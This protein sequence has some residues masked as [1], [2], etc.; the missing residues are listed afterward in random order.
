MILMSVWSV[1]T[2]ATDH[3]A[4]TWAKWMKRG[5]FY[6]YLWLAPVIVPLLVYVFYPV[7]SMIYMSGY[8]Y[9]IVRPAETHFVGLDNYIQLLSDTDLWRSLKVSAIWVLGSVAPQ[10]LLGLGMALLLHQRFGGRGAARTM[11][12]MPWVL[13]GVVTGII[14]LWL[15]DGTIGVINDLLLRA[16]LVER[17][18]AWSIRPG[19]AFFMLF[20]ANAWRGAPFFAIT[21]LAALQGIS[22]EIYEAAE[23]D[24]AGSWQRFR[25]VTIPLIMNVVI[26]TTLL[27]A[28]WTFNWVDLIWTMTKGGPFNSTRTLAMYIFDTAYLYGDFG[29]AAALSVVLCVVLIIFS[30]LYWRLN[31]FTTEM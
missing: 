26:V 15:F 5:N 21:L 10:F 20:V 27:R 16:H 13:S 1:A 28:I 17:P 31:R 23:I 3:A 24:G 9:V 2:Q 7:S 19:S 8:H 11:F 18:V 4:Q 6:P 22:P 14:W 30:A 29:Y 12:L 25:Y